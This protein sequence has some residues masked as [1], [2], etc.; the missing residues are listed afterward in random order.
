MRTCKNHC[1]EQLMKQA[2]EQCIV[3][4][5]KPKLLLNV[6]YGWSYVLIHPWSKRLKRHSTRTNGNSLS[7]EWKFCPQCG[8][9]LDR[10]GE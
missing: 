5:I 3:D 1:I 9:P 6:G 10:E 7:V 2:S 4:S 8:E